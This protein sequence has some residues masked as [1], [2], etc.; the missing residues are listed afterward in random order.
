MIREPGSP[1]M[2]ASDAAGPV[3]AFDDAAALA[4]RLHDMR[5]G[6]GLDCQPGHGSIDGADPFP[7][8][9]VWL[10]PR[11]SEP[12]ADRRFLAVV[13]GPGARSPA[14]ILTALSQTAGRRAA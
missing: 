8:V 4:R 10:S 11:R 9:M 2:V 6:W 1:V 14:E 7:G 13:A 3:E 12:A 5:R